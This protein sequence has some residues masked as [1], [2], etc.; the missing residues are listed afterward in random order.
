MQGGLVHFAQCQ[1]LQ[2]RPAFDG[3]GQV[4]VAFHG[5]QAPAH[6]QPV[7]GF[8]QVL[9]GRSLDGGGGCDDPIQAAVL[10]NPFGGGLGAHLLHAGHVVHRVAHEG[11]V[12]DD[13]LGRHA[14]LGQDP[15]FIQRFVAHGVDQAHIGRDQLRQVF[16]AGGNQHPMTAGG[17][18]ARQGADDVIGFDAADLKHGPTQQA[19][20]FVDGLDLLHQGLGH[21]RAVALVVGV[22]L[23]AEGGP[24]CVEH[25]GRML[26]GVL[27]AQALH[28]GHH[29]VHR[30]RGETGGRAQVGHRVEGA[31]EVAGAV[32]QEHQG[33]HR[34]SVYAPCTHGRLHRG[35]RTGGPVLH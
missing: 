11:E 8:A 21:G 12:V 13:A 30:P 2:R 31:V 23:V 24:G 25:T 19:H 3:R 35:L 27:L 15:G 34:M 22:P 7:Q 28:H 33:F 20:H 9:A 6:G 32:D 5:D 10:R 26:G 1:A 17:R 18:L 29:A 14:E 16:V 4:A